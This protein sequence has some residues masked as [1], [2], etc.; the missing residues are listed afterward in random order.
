MS[1]TVQP[2][3]TLDADK[4]VGHYLW[5]EFSRALEQALM[6][7]PALGMHTG[8]VH[9]MWSQ[10]V[11][12]AELLEGYKYVWTHRDRQ[13][14]GEPLLIQCK[15]CGTVQKWSSIYIKN[16]GSYRFECTYSKCGYDGD[17]RKRNRL[18]FTVQRPEGAVFLPK[19]NGGQGA[20]MKTHIELTVT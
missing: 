5:F 19:C 13:P 18:Q 14:W 3:R 1:A 10:L 6:E 11:G 4:Q 8:A 9:L 2:C 12:G 16:N 20:W 17:E 7:C 15:Q